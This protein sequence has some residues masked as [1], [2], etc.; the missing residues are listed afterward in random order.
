[1]ALFFIANS[2]IL[3][4]KQI[5]SVCTT[6]K[7]LV[8]FWL[9]KNLRNTHRYPLAETEEGEF[10]LVSRRG[11]FIAFVTH[12]GLLHCRLVYGLIFF[13]GARPI[14]NWDGDVHIWRS[15]SDDSSVV[16]LVAETTN[17]FL[18]YLFISSYAHVIYLLY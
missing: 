4:S 14:L 3:I 17:N 12:R 16:L 1:M 6:L 10:S 9:E 15:R 13:L 11:S 8:K 2:T 5:A 7:N 18:I